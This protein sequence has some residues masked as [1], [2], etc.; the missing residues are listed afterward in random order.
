MPSLDTV[1]LP[2]V[3][4]SELLSLGQLLRNP[5]SPNADTYTKG[6]TLVTDDDKAHVA[7]EAPYSTI[8]SLDTR[9]R[10][11]VGLT[12]YL[13]SRFHGRTT[14]LLSIEAAKL[15]YHALKNATDVF[16][17]VTADEDARAWIKNM[18]VHKT[19]C[20]FVI[21]LQVLCAADFKRAVLKEGGAGAYLTLPLETTA[22]IPLHLKGEVS[23]D[24]FAK[25]TGMV[26]GVFG[27]QVQ[28]LRGKIDLAGNPTLEGDASWR[29][30]HQRVKGSQLEEDK[31]LNIKLEDVGLDELVELLRRD[32]ED[33]DDDDNE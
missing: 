10:F 5:L 4:P 30:S 14:T 22:Q 19:P 31:V 27:V 18:V 7:A 33:D 20:Y 16:K 25:S 3:F 15:E 23:V 2:K 1:L 29:W 11:D 17:R 9:G 21:G 32:D 6:C 13:G 26:S 12:K 8:V 28:R 24:R